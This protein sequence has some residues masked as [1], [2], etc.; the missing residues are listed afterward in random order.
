M[1]IALVAMFVMTMSANA[2]SNNSR[3]TMERLSSYL[4]L[5][6]DQQEP[7]KTALAQ[8][9]SSM[10]A[11]YQLKDQSKGQE[12]WQKIQASHKKT[13]KK[14]LS[15]KQYNKYVQMLDLTVKNTAERIVEKKLASR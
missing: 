4:Q 10:E 9:T 14:V 1:M 6:V 12:A 8:F 7:V 11:L 5:T 2:Q 13:M 15:E 3:L